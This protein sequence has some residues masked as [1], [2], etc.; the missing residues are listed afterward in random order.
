MRIS[1]KIF[2]K[3]RVLSLNV[4]IDKASNE[5]KVTQKMKDIYRNMFAELKRVILSLTFQYSPK[6]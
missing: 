6:T 4:R 2:L 1:Q 5:L 3:W